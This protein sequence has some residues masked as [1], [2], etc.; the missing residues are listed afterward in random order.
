MY[1]NKLGQIIEENVKR[2]L[3]EPGI[4]GDFYSNG[5]SDNKVSFYHCIGYIIML[6]HT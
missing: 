6:N 2:L 1:T 5:L 4:A 3:D